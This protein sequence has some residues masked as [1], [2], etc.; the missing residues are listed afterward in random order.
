MTNRLTIRVNKHDLV[1]QRG[2]IELILSRV[3]LGPDQDCW[4]WTGPKKSGGYGRHSLWKHGRR[5]EVSAHRIVYSV[6]VEPVPEG[7]VPDHLCQNSICV[8]PSHLEIVTMAENSRRNGERRTHC[9]RKHEF[10]EENTRRGPKGERF[11]RACWEEVGRERHRGYYQQNKEAYK[12][13]SELYWKRKLGID[14]G[15][16]CGVITKHGTVCGKPEGHD[17][18]H[19]PRRKSDG[20]SE[21]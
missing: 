8:N 19:Y 16:D 5:F 7:L 21:V 9:K 4:P 17:G 20:P 12:Q 2:D 14:V 11:C 10:T 3:P 15:P 13:R 1:L 18:R 6:L